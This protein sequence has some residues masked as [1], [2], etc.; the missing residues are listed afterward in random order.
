MRILVAEDDALLAFDLVDTLKKVGAEIVGPAATLKQ[1]LSLVNT[2]LLSAAILDVNLRDEDVYPAA[3]A[4]E[5]IGVGFVF[6]TSCEGA[7]ELSRAWPKVEALRKPA[8]P[9]LLIE[10]VSRACKARMLS[11][12]PL[13]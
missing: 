11:A 9:K 13:P 6:Y 4:L 2:P 3:T 12:T 10:A 7:S 5:G 8:P 1:T